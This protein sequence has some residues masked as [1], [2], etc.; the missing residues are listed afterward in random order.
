MPVIRLSV[1]QDQIEINPRRL[2][3]AAEAILRG[4]GFT[5]TELSIVIV[6]DEEMARLN[7]QYRHVDTATDVLAFPMLEGEFGDVVPELLGDIV[8][9]A[10]T[11]QVMSQR[12]HCP[13]STVLD[14]LLVHGVLHLI[15]Y[16]HEHTP[17]DS[18]RME[19]KSVELL[20]MLGHSRESL[21]W[22]MTRSDD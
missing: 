14:L 9:S 3:K 5:D 2:K 1:N 10:P 8:I 12:F 21:D 7:M 22:Y 13:L 17:E 19:G 15:G 4:L 11:A 6:N 18:R 16:D 20:R